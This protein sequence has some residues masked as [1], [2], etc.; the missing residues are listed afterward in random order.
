VGQSLLREP[1]G[2]TSPGGG[3]GLHLLYEFHITQ[4]FF[5]GVDLTWRMYP[6]TAGAAASI[7]QIGYGLRMRHALS[8]GEV[9]PF[10]VYGLLLQNTRLKGVVGSLT[11]HDTLLG[12]GVD[13]LAARRKFFLEG[14]WH[15]SRAGYLGISTHTVLDYLQLVAGHRWQW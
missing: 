13:F 15:Y 2:A 3:F 7:H 6:S 4:K 5:L 10:L 12:A 1:F 14:S 8:S 9:Q 11:S